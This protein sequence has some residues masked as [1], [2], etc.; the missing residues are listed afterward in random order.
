VLL[1]ALLAT[2]LLFS[3]KEFACPGENKWCNKY[4]GKEINI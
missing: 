1:W 2:L 3:L 4:E